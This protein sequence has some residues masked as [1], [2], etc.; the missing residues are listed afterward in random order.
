MKNF[1]ASFHLDLENSFDTLKWRFPLQTLIILLLT[2]VLLYM[3]NTEVTEPVQIKLALTCVVTFFFSIGIRLFR[4]TIDTRQFSLYDIIPFIY[5]VLFYFTVEPTTNWGLESFVYFALHLTGFIS[6]T[7][8]APYLLEL[9]RWKIERIEYT[10]YFTRVAWTFLMSV[11]VGI[12]VLL[13]GF[14]AIASVTALFDLAE[15]FREDKAYANWAVL[16]LALFAPL[17]WL[18]QIPYEKNV[19]TLKFEVNKFF[20]FLIRFV[21]TPFIYI[22]FFILYAYTVKVLLNFSD[23]PKGMISWMVIGFSTFGYLTYIFSLAYEDENR[24][25]RIFRKYFP[26]VVIPQI[27]MLAYA[28][29]LRISQYD[30]TMNRYFVVV[31]GLWLLGVSIY[32]IA[33]QRKSLVSITASLAIISLLISVGPWSVYSL[34][35]YRQ[36]DRLTENLEKAWLMQNGAIVKGT[37]TTIEP[38]L[39]NDIY[40]GIQYVCDFDECS[41]LKELF[42]AEY[43]KAYDESKKNWDSYT[44]E[45]KTAYDGPSSYEIVS[46][47]TTSLWINYRYDAENPTINKY[48]QLGNEKWI[49]DN[50][51]YPISV[52]GYDNMVRIYSDFNASPATSYL[53][54]KPDSNEII[55][56]DNGTTSTFS[57]AEFNDK[58]RSTYG[59]ENRWNIPTEALITTVS[60]ENY[61]IKLIFQSYSILNTSWQPGSGDTNYYGVSGFALIKNL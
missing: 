19:D 31:F 18:T 24:I 41:R 56:V 22:Y 32:L 36:Y 59:T 16:S 4:E 26:I 25:V 20:S 12:S 2:G 54:V 50:T 43:Q 39:Q 42:P 46:A 10:N 9:F 60:N 47:V 27:G 1:L 29:G 23:W 21:A 7:F 55:F 48:I 52:T 30:L 38:T 34:P 28:I 14:I 6:F 15:F 45:S 61:E 33:S 40:S 57:L 37:G 8:F 44:Y 35:L 13:L 11:I 53:Q 5:G 58:L 51:L 3:V 49:E 17:F